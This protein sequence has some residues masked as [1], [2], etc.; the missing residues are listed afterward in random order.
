MS[1]A[2]I[3]IQVIG[4]VL[5]VEGQDGGRIDE[6]ARIAMG[7]SLLVSVVATIAVTLLGPVVGTVYGDGYEDVPGLLVVLV[8]GSVPYSV[9]VVGLN[10]A[11]IASD[12]GRTLVMALGFSTVVLLPTLVFAQSY[13]A[14]GVAWSWLGGNVVAAILVARATGRPDHDRAPS[15]SVVDVDNTPAVGGDS[16]R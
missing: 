7:V 13:E 10:R 9:T 14:T 8:L 5:L 3:S 2:V 12:H 4:Q 1:V 15:T 11:R 16:A 6:Q